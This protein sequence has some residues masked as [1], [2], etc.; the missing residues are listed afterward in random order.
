MLGNENK[1]I[2]LFRE[3][4]VEQQHSLLDFAEFLHARSVGKNLE[5]IPEYVE[6]PRPE[7]E[8]VVAAIKRLAK[9]YPMLKRSVMMKET[10]DLMTDHVM[11][12]RSA[13]EVIDDLE[14]VFKTHYHHFQK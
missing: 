2:E 1:L 3:L 5:N 8:S 14:H 11:R 12:G 7:S 10:A 13:K 4:D 9:T 6:I